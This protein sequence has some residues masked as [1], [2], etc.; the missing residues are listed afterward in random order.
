[1]QMNTKENKHTLWELSK[2]FFVSGMR[3]N[4]IISLFESVLM[5]VDE[6]CKGD[7]T[8]KNKVFLAEFVNALPTL[9]IEVG[10][11]IIEVV[12]LSSGTSTEDRLLKLEAQVSE[13]LKLLKEITFVDQ[14]LPP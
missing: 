9:E 2:T 12:D 3:R 13:I 4:D 6:R 11:P 5:N 8:E 1:M 10:E 14:R 7:L